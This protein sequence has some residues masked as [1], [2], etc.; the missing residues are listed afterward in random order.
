MFPYCSG[1][2]PFGEVDQERRQAQQAMGLGG[3]RE[4][5]VHERL[6]VVEPDVPRGDRA[7]FAGSGVAGTSARAGGTAGQCDRL[8]DEWVPGGRTCRSRPGWCGKG[9]GLPQG[10]LADPGTR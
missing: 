9:D 6:D 2:L 3:E 1:V 7:P 8:M 5:T 10:L 4:A